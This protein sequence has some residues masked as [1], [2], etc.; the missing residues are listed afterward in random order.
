MESFMKR[1]TFLAMA[2]PFVATGCVG[3]SSR[4]HAPSSR[5][6]VQPERPE[7]EV[8][9]RSDRRR[10]RQARARRLKKARDRRRKKAR[11][12]RLKEARDRRRK[13][14]LRNHRR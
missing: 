5:G 14:R 8:H 12:R 9:R 2:I 7:A 11:A 13:R 10:R 3:L 6:G 1:R 4:V